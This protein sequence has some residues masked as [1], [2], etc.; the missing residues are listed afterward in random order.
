MKSQQFGTI[1]FINSAA[2]KQGYFNHSLYSATKFGLNGYAQSLKLEAKK[3]GIRVISVYPGGVKTNLYRDVKE[4]P[5][6]SEYMDADKVAEIV[7]FLAE[8][9]ALSPDEISISRMSR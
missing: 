1:V 6:T 4:K 5:D 8:T 7:V 3:N 9:E 2:G